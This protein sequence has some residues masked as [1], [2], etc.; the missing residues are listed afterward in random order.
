MTRKNTV[1]GARHISEEEEI[2]RIIESYKNSMN[3][4]I[5]KLEASAIQAQRSREIFWN[6]DKAKK[7]LMKLRG[8]E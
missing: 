5:T 1:W 6:N 8:I 2:Y 3:T 7:F 4:E